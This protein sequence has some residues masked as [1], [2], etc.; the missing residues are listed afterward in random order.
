ME[1]IPALARWWRALADALGAFLDE[2][3]FRIGLAC[4]VIAGRLPLEVERRDWNKSVEA[5]ILVD[6]F[7]WT[8]DRRIFSVLV[9]PP[10]GSSPADALRDHRVRLDQVKAVIARGAAEMA[11]STRFETDYGLKWNHE[12]QVWATSDGFAFDG[13]K[14][15]ERAR[16]D[17]MSTTLPREE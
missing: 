16:E 15:G 7:D 5:P 6:A 9:W 14:T 4:R 3:A 13:K 8:D 11:W 10:L 2:A 17:L 1:V 12:R